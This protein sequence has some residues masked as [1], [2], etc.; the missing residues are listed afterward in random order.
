MSTDEQCVMLGM[1]KHELLP[2]FK[3]GKGNYGSV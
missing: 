1:N 2:F 3:K